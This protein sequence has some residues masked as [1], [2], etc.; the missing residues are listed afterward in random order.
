[1]SDETRPLSREPET[2]PGPSE[3]TTP[4]A[5]PPM[6]G[7]YPQAAFAYPATEPTDS[8]P[9]SRGLRIALLIVG[10]VVV[11]AMLFGGGFWT[12]SVVS[13]FTGISDSRFGG[14]PRTGPGGPMDH[15]RIPGRDD[16]D[17]DS[18]TDGDGSADTSSL[19]G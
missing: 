14:D 8:R 16:D 7:P 19:D 5:A 18:G 11:A 3:A 9:R 10:A 4:A 1:M 15:G 17:S 12:G 13:S 6:P 2:A